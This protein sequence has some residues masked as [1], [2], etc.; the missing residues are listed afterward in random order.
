VAL[1]GTIPDAELAAQTGRTVG[2]V[3]QKRTAMG[4]PSSRDRRKR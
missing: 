2:A 1:P 4:I 3:R